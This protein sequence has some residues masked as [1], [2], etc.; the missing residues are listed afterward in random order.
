MK[1]KALLTAMAFTMLA[2]TVSTFAA[3]D[4][5]V[6]G[7][8]HERFESNLNITG[9]VYGQ[10]NTAPSGQI[11]MT[12]PS[13]VQ[14]TVY[15]DNSVIGASGMK[16]KNNSSDVNVT[17]SI[18]SFLDTTPTAKE[19]ITLVSNFSDGSSNYDRSHVK[20]SLTATG[21]ETKVLTHGMSAGK[22]VDLDA[23]QISTLTLSGEAGTGEHGTATNSST[24]DLN[25][26]GISNDFVLTFNI[27]KKA[28]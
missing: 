5:V 14:F 11:S 4:N 8:Q 3:T 13:A 15:E 24:T 2:P 16:I 17:V 21:G 7:S 12:L 19:G 22:L 25:S 26:N 23:Q 20:L 6:S 27:A 28:N 10:D 18:G 1:N 9:S